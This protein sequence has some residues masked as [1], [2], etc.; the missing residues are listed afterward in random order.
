MI[1]YAE[2]NNGRASESPVA[3]GQAMTRDIFFEIHQ[4]LPREGPG[5]NKYTRKAFRMLPEL[6]KPRILDVGCG[7]GGPTLELAR[8]SQGKVIGLE[9]QQPFLDRLTRKIE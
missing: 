7:P 2:Y 3:D 6:D 1:C 5:R 8:L 9:T 4:K